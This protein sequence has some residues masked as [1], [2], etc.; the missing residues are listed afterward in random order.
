M[1]NFRYLWATFGTFGQLSAALGSFL[2]FSSP[3][4]DNQV[5]IFGAFG[6]F[7]VAQSTKSFVAKVATDEWF[8]LFPCRISVNEAPEDYDD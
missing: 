1:G 3:G 4:G 2:N 7:F 6:K 5:W 8:E